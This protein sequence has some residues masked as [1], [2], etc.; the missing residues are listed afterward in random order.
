MKAYQKELDLALA[1]IT[2]TRRQFMV[3][4]DA[5]EARIRRAMPTTPTISNSRRSNK[6]D[7][8]YYKQLLEG[9]E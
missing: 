6:K 2:A 1:A 7:K 9:A 4:L 3:D 5:I 8:E